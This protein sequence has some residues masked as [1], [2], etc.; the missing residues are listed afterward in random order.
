MRDRSSQQIDRMKVH[1]RD[2]LMEN[3]LNSQGSS[4]N[5]DELSSRVEKGELSAFSAAWSWVNENGQ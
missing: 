3:R 2:L 4:S 1:A 5:W